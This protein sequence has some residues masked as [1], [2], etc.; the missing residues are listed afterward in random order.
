VLPL[1]FFIKEAGLLY[2]LV[3]VWETLETVS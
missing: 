3:S 2:C 1:Y